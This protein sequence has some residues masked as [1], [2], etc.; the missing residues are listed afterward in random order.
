[1]TV[2]KEEYIKMLE[3]HDWYWRCS[4]D[5]RKVTAGSENER[6]LK[7]MAKSN[8]EFGDLYNQYENKKVKR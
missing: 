6:V 5:N 3:K 7:A 8:S 1:M 2:N 4:D